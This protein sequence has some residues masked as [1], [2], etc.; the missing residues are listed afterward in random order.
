MQ[1]SKG[2]NLNKNGL[3]VID[4]KIQGDRLYETTI[5]RKGQEKEVEEILAG[6]IHS[7]YQAKRNGERPR[8]KFMDCAIKYLLDN[9]DQKQ[10]KSFEGYLKRIHPY[11]GH[12]DA[13]ELHG[14]HPAIRKLIDDQLVKG[15]KKRSVNH[16]IE[17]INRVLQAATKWRHEWCELTWLESAPRIDL[18]HANDTR[19]GRPLTWDQ[20][21]RLL[22]C[23]PLH[24]RDEVICYVNTGLRN[25]EL[26]SLRW[27]KLK[28]FNNGTIGFIANNKGT[29]KDKNR[30]KLVVCN[31]TVREIIERK[32]DEH[33]THV[34]SYRGRPKTSARGTAWRNGVK[35]SGLDV[36][37]HDLRYTFAHRLRAAGVDQETRAELLGHGV[38]LTSKYSLTTLENVT[39]AVALIEE[40]TDH[41]PMID[42]DIL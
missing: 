33:P 28:K 17:A 21:D 20:Q 2:Y 10:I 16:Y 30:K 26:F 7:V 37:I 29:A 39:R 11:I 34:F 42:L 19:M 24:V 22:A 4:K 41:E 14:D 9:D 27:D 35:E 8:V 40:R 13:R 6:S 3:Y 5:F 1:K 25:R 38:S 12:I 32:R 15:N 31:N 18:L 36:N 23:L